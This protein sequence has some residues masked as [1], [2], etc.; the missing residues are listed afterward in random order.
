MPATC[1]HGRASWTIETDSLRLTLLQSGGHLA[2][3]VLKED[4]T[5]NPLWVPSRPTIDPETY[6]PEI[7]G[8]IY[9][10]NPESR[11]LSG[12]AGHNLC[13]PFWGNPSPSEFAAGMTFHGE[14][15]IRRWQLIEEC[16]GEITIEVALL[17]SVTKMRRRFRAQG[18]ALHCESEALNLSTWDRP[19]GW[20]EHV[21]M[22]PPFVE[23]DVVRFDAALGKGFVTGDS[24]GPHFAWPEGL[25]GCSEVPDFDLTW[26]SET[27]HGDM[28]NSF[29][30]EPNR[31]WAYFTVFHKGFGLLFGYVY[32]RADYP[33][34]N[35]WECNNEKMKARGM[36]FSNTPHHG[37]MKTLISMPN[38]WDVP[39]YEWLDARS[40]V[41]KR[42]TAF[43]HPVPMD[44]RGTAD[45]QVGPYAFEVIERD[46][47]RLFR[48]PV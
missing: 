15:N 46:T 37:T 36:E 21:T 23:S 9:G 31:D 16:P 47:G 13:F 28:V 4:A 19:F 33:W 1:F 24:L 48:V 8:T 14:S 22:G 27:A 10:R 41:R 5:V 20:C 17:E 6:D 12:L 39:T 3:I 30:V 34:L 25:S 18:H 40:T 29:L 35:V 2:E 11:L 44:Y 7:H 26:F 42:F 43:L 45:I 38:M 32:P